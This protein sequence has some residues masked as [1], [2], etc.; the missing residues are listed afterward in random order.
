MQE[1]QEISLNYH[2]DHLK[3]FFLFLFIYVINFLCQP[4]TESGNKDVFEIDGAC[5]RYA[6]TFPR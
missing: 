6:G 2:K 4:G 5:L 3:I 1:V